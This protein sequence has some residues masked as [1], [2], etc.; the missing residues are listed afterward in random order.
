VRGTG[1]IAVAL[2]LAMALCMALV[3][4]AL[5]GLPPSGQ[6]GCTLVTPSFEEPDQYLGD[7]KIKGN[8][9]RINKSRWGKLV[10]KGNHKIKFKTGAWKGR[11]RGFWER[12][13]SVLEPGKKITEIELTEIESGFESSYC[14]KE[15]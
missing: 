15:K 9:Y 4:T 13:D 10:D 5:A 14:T 6:Y 8:E 12:V 7:L 11:F 2:L 1:K 3:P